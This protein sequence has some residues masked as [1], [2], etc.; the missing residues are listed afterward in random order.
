MSYEVERNA[1]RRC[2]DC[3]HFI[4]VVEQCDRDQDRDNWHAP[5][6]EACEDWGH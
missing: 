5:H 1:A 6:D 4:P 3:Q 2:G